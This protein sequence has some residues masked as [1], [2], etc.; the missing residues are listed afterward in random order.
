M[1]ISRRMLFMLV[2]VLVVLVASTIAY[3]A[4]FTD[5][6]GHWAEDEITSMYEE[7]IVKGHEDGTYGPE[8]LVT[9]AQMA[10][11]LD[12]LHGDLSAEMGDGGMDADSCKACH[13]DSSLITGKQTAWAMS[14]HGA[15]TAY[16]YAGG[17]SGCTGCHSGEGFSAM[18][19]AGQS[20]NEVET[21][22]GEPTRQDCRACHDIHTSYTDAD[23]SLETTAAVD[24]FEVEGATY[25]GGEG[26]LCANCHQVRHI[27]SDSVSADGESATIDSTH[28]G[29]HHGPQSAV[30]LGIAGAGDVEG[31]PSMHYSLVGD[32]CV[33]CH[34][35]ENNNHTF[36]PDTAACSTCH[37]DVDDFDI[38]G[39]QTDIQAKLDQ[40]E[41]ALK[42]D[43]LFDAEGGVVT[44]TY[45]T[46]KAAAVWDWT[47]LS[48]DGSLGVHNPDYAMDLL[49]AG[50]AA[51]E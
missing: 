48:E 41:A 8:E 24:M 4:V 45:A 25:D 23:W 9:R 15:G 31:S 36:E 7:G 10:V 30:L 22:S 13:D 3:A 37:G 29:A 42:A 34:L 33:T 1:R 14:G 47:M 38:D 32:T 20:P 46:A 51:F 44:G 26:N 27:F 11:F 50:L 28:W 12:R 49:D 6:T 35:G 16:D 18:V 5:I 17:R 43:G 39:T 19:A 2:T 40:L 21:A